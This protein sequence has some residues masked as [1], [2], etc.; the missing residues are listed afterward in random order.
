MV[1]YFPLSINCFSILF[2]KCNHLSLR[3]NPLC[4]AEILSLSKI[5]CSNLQIHFFLFGLWRMRRTYMLH[6]NCACCC[7][8]VESRILLISTLV[9]VFF[10][11]LPFA[12]THYLLPTEL[13]ILSCCL[14]G[15]L[16]ICL[17]FLLGYNF[18]VIIS[19]FKLANIYDSRRP[20]NVTRL[21]RLLACYCRLLLS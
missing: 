13:C 9:V 7:R 12:A 8:R 21:I 20:L 14:I 17:Q 1:M 19:T 16:E 10:L 6:L 18:S 4:S 11:I 5:T 3:I 15:A 2:S